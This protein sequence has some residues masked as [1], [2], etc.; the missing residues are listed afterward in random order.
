M[1]F[2]KRWFFFSLI[3]SQ[4]MR[5]PLTE[6]FHPS[7][8]IQML[9]DHRMVDIKF[10]SNFSCSCKRISFNDCP[11][12]VVVNF[13]WAATLLLIFLA[14]VSVAKLFAPLNYKFVSSSWDKYMVDDESCL[15]ALDPF[16]TQLRKLVEFAFCLTSFS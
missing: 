15:S 12:L 5:H 14:L 7:N 2:Q 16:W 13:W 10:F 8:F 1:T 6:L 11:Q 3:S 9:N 4:L